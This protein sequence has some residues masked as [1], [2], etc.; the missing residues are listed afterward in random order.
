ML[1]LRFCRFLRYLYALSSKG[2]AFRGQRT[3]TQHVLTNLTD[4]CFEYLSDERVL[5]PIIL[6]VAA[7]F[8]FQYS[9]TL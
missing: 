4:T 8:T 7:H 5:L 9:I 2:T 6:Y 1:P 3:Y